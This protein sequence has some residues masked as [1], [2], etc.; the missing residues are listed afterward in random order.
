MMK[1]TFGSLLLLAALSLPVCPARAGVTPLGVAIVPPVQF[2]PGDFTIVGARVSALWGAQRNVYGVDLG[3]LGNITEGDFGG[4]AVAGL[5][6]WNK[7][8]STI[9]GLQAAGL[10]NVNV[11]KTRVLGVQLAAVNANYAESSVTGFQLGLGNYSPHTRV[12]GAQLGIYNSSREVYG[13][14]IGLINSTD[15]L[16]GI[17]VGLLNFNRSGLFS[18]A[19]ILNVG[20]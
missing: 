5:A 3:G 16:H 4:I 14:Q 11:N 18:V 8:T 12:I 10:A 6:N 7:G 13:F 17:Q 15:S 1:K 20:F 9:I 19:P 2:P